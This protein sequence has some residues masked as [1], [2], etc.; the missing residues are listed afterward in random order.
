MMSAVSSL[1][2]VAFAWLIGALLTGLLWP[3]RGEA[4]LVLSVGAGVGL[5]VTS[6]IFFFASLV[7]ANPFPVAFAAELLLSCS[8]LF[9]WLRKRRTLPPALV[10]PAQPARS[11]LGALVRWT[12]VAACAL[13]LFSTVAAWR[14]E[15]YGSWDG[16]ALWNMKARFLYRGGSA[17]YSQMVQPP[18]TWTHPDYPLLV[19]ASVARSWA[20]TGSDSPFATGLVATVFGV[21]TLGLLVAGVHRLRNRLIALT[22]GLVLLGTPFFVRF[23]SNE[24]ADIPV[25]FFMLAATV[26]LGIARDEGDRGVLFLAGLATGLAAWTKNEGL[27]FCVVLGLVF[28]TTQLVTKRWRNLPPLLGGL[29]LALLPVLW[30][31]FALAP[32]NDIMAGQHADGLAKLADWSRHQIILKAWW[33]D[34]PKFGEWYSLPFLVMLLHLLGP[35]RGWFDRRTVVTGAILLLMLAGYYTVYLLSP[36]DLAWHL[37]S[38]LVRLLMQVWPVAVFLWCLL[39]VRAGP[40]AAQTSPAESPAGSPPSGQSA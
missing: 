23:S 15:P 7:S 35:V 19:P 8:L 17:G 16:W 30:F 32:P 36:Y 28:S 22:G 18:L 14:V 27:L 24:H 11:W 34:L 38:S 1:F 21:A 40:A 4:A 6:L 12:F 2:A 9:L 5:G 29:A 31:K 13:A 33:R 26:L 20:Y 25:G 37:D 3:R 10:A 39:A